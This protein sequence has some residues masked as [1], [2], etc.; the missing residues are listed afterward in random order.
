MI[1]IGMIGFSNNKRALLSKLIRFFTKSHLSHT[2]LIHYP[3]ADIASVH[4]A[5]F[6]VQVVPFDRFYHNHPDKQ[7]WIYKVNGF[8]EEAKIE[9]LRKCFNEFAG[10]KYG[11]FQILW[12]V[13][14][15]FNELFNRD[16]R[17]EKNWFTDGV[18]CSELVYWYL[19]YLSDPLPE[20][21]KEFTPDTIQADDLHKLVINNPHLFELVAYKI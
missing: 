18:I 17:S 2:F 20:L 19:H 8:T 12:F 7:Y 15:W 3:Q 16:I 1:E 11:K 9:A 14:R 10:I 5:S 21:L 4:E 13:W 6:V